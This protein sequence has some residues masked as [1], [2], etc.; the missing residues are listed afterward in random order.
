LLQKSYDY[1]VLCFGEEKTCEILFTEN[2]CA[3]GGGDRQTDR[4]TNSSCNGRV[5]LKTTS[6]QS[7]LHVVRFTTRAG[8]HHHLT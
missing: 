2:A 3:H 6:Q 1:F 8:F 5:P 4:Q 7:Q